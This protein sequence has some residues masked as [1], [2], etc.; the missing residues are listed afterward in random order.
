M[1]ATQKPKHTVAGIRVI[2]EPNAAG[3]SFEVGLGCHYTI[4]GDTW[5]GTV[6]AI[7]KNGKKVAFSRDTTTRN[8]LGPK[9][10]HEPGGVAFQSNIRPM[11]ELEVFSLRTK[12]KH[13]GKY[14]NGT[15]R[16]CVELRLGRRYYL[17]PS[18]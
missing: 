10:D 4:G 3:Q 8:T 16:G 7:S 14:T 2:S 6:Q 17:D 12:G 5:P 9:L 11:R 18:F 15:G 1:S 13:A